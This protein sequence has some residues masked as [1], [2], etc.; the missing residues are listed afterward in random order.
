[1]G[2]ELVFP[3]NKTGC[4]RFWLHPVDLGGFRSGLRK[5]MYDLEGVAYPGIDSVVG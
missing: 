5:M 1:M 4:N 2:R 3:D